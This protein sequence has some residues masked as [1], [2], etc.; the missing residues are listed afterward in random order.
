LTLSDYYKL[1][2][3]IKNILLHKP[4]H[5][6]FKFECLSFIDRNNTVW[7]IILELN[8]IIPVNK[9]QAIKFEKKKKKT[10]KKTKKKN[11]HD[12]GFEEKKKKNK[13]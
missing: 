9:G 8:G 1:H 11:P 10:K 3:N 6:S 13:N 5:V 2:V 12:I 7:I 4:N